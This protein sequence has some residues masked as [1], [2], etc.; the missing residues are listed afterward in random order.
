MI[1]II[2]NTGAGFFSCFRTTLSTIQWCDINNMTPYVIWDTSLYNEDKY[3][4]NAWEYYFQQVSNPSVEDLSVAKEVK[5]KY[6]TRAPEAKIAYHNMIQKH[7][8]IKPDIVNIVDTF[9]K[10][11]FSKVDTLGVHIR[12]TDKNTFQVERDAGGSP[13]DLSRYIDHIHKYIDNKDSVKVFLATDCY[14]TLEAVKREFGDLVICRDAIR[15]HDQSPVHHM[16]KNESA[17]QKG[18]DVLVDALLLSR[19]NFLIKGSSSVAIA[20]LLFNKDLK[21]ENMNYI[22]H[23]DSREVWAS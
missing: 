3:G 19:T 1:G 8:K 7:V 13:V 5:Q 20:A 4:S 23:N 17:Y 10:D 6:M 18:Q 2:K 9:Y 21:H 16:M 12:Q 22:Y 14:N 15:S 11:R